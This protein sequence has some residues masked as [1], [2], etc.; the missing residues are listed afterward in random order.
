MSNVL[1][2]Y[3]DLV[4]PAVFA[5]ALAGAAVLQS[6]ARNDVEEFAAKNPTHPT[7]VQHRNA[8]H[9]HPGL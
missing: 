5:V 9:Q 7:V 3:K 8:Y 4:A 2:K 6:G 1:G